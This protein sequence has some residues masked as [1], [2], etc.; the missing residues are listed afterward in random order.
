MG[1][2]GEMSQGERA[3]RLR[4]RVL[5]TGA[6]GFLG[7]ATAVA[8]SSAGCAVLRGARTSFGT[9]NGLA[10]SARGGRH[11]RSCGWPRASGGQGRR[12][13]AL[14]GQRRRH[15]QPGSLRRCAR[16]PSLH[17]DQLGCGQRLD[18]RG[19][20]VYRGQRRATRQF[21]RA[22][23]IGGRD[24]AQGDRAWNGHGMR[25]TSP[26]ARLW[27]RRARQLPPPGQTCSLGA[28]ASPRLRN[29][30]QKL[31]CH[32]QSH[33][34]DREVCRASCG[35]ESNIPDPGRG[36]GVYRPAHPRHCRRSRPPRMD[37]PHPGIGH[38]SGIL[39]SRT[40]G[41]FP[42]PL[43]TTGH[44]LREGPQTPG[45]VAHRLDGRGLAKGH[46]DRSPFDPRHAV[47]CNFPLSPIS[48][49]PA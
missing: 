5:V 43:R 3:S 16:R 27:F 32:R 42:T 46:S 9:V 22:L 36:A 8:L 2:D 48:R 31:H 30:T 21:L 45:L 14:A 23:Q 24:S 4:G 15:G 34:C 39:S 49:V 33:V 19:N 44:R 28:P 1:T 25:D 10:R 6:T 40:G 20:A 41:R 17:S 47:S 11:D 26:A 38:A 35:G 13:E 29:R 7:G 12:R 18:N 37:A